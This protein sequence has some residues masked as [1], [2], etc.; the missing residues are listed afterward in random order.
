M[1]TEAV[2]WEARGD[3]LRKAG[4]HDDAIEAY[5]TA[6]R[7]CFQWKWDAKACEGI[8]E[9]IWAVQID[10]FE[11]YAAAPGGVDGEADQHPD[12]VELVAAKLWVGGSKAQ[13]Q[14]VVENAAKAGFCGCGEFLDRLANRWEANHH[15]PDGAA[16][17]RQQA[18]LLRGGWSSSAKAGA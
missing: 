1:F 12:T 9:K 5:R 17:L 4:R 2:E 3:G 11:A 15:D 14:Q 13:A 18:L 10:V 16:W 8:R 7:H 6:L